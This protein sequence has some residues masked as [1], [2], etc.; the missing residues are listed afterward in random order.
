MKRILCLSILL[1]TALMGYGQVTSGGSAEK[2][3]V[4]LELQT[5]VQEAILRQADVHS[6]NINRTLT[7]TYVGSFMS[8]DGPNWQSNPS[9]YSGVEAAALIFG[10]SPSDYAISTNPDITD[11]STI[12]HTAW[13]SIWGIGCQ[14]L[15]EDYSLDLGA[16]GY[17]D[18]GGNN[19]AASAYVQDWCFGGQTNYVW[20]L[21]NLSIPFVT[22]WE[23]T[24]AGESITIPTTG[25][26]YNYSVDWGDGSTDV[27]VMGD[28]THA[29]AVPGVYMVTVNGTF[30]QIYFHNEGDRLKIR[31]IEQWGS[32]VWRSMDDAFAGCENLVS[33]ATDVPDLSMVADMSNMFTYARKFNGDAVFHTWDVSN[34][35]NMEALFAGASVFNRDIDSWDVGNVTNMQDMFHG[36]TKFNKSLNSWDVGSVTNMRAMFATAMNFNGNIGSWDVSNV[37]DMY[38]M[39]AYARKFNSD[40][41]GWNVGNVTTMYG[42]FG[43]ASVFNRDIG[44]WDVSNVTDMKNMFNGATKFNKDIGSWNVGNV[45]NMKKMFRTAMAFNQDIGSWDVGSVTTMESMF[46]HA[47]HFDQNL[48]S[49]DVSNVLSMSNMFKGIALSTANYDAFLEACNLFPQ[50]N[51]ILN[52]GDSKYCAGALARQNLIDNHNWTI[53]D[54]GEEC[55]GPIVADRSVL[56]DHEVSLGLKGITLAPNPMEGHFN[57]AN[58]G[59]IELERLSIYDLTGRLI[60]TVDLRGTASEVTIDVADLITSTYLVV[61]NGKDDQISRLMVKK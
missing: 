31:T 40:I 14:E 22:T 43:G 6:A 4:P 61:I 47:S 5:Q 29:Y 50:N 37:T 54:G 15:P 39:F 33:N 35:T 55:L 46:E 20:A 58:P 42:M 21:N 2:S 44:S 57:L 27:G 53:T 36:A 23:T 28:A 30:P 13:V 48:G 51:V 34:V 25:G 17:N 56:G 26:G 9:V 59:N 8:N 3:I 32:T 52:G 24:V 12:T 49:W 11:P 19:T 16:P 1:C 38:G 7:A 18:P 41:S 10:G 60:R 45:T